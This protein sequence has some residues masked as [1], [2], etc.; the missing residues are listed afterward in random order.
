MGQHKYNPTTAKGDT[1]E[2]LQLIHGASAG[3]IV[4][5]DA[6]KVQVM[7]PRYVD[8]DGIAMLEMELSIVP[9][10]GDD[11]FLITIR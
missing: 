11:D 8:L 1:T 9:D 3:G 2:A 7:N 4:A 5:L 6:P 10:A